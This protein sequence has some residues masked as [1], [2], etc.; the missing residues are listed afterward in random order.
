MRYISNLTVANSQTSIY[1]SLHSDDAR[2]PSKNN[3]CVQNVGGSTKEAEN[4][5]FPPRM[6]RG[7]YFYHGER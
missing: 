3:S 7:I 6:G 2:E 1:V 5:Q 4:I